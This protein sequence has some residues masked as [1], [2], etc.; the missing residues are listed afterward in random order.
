M[1]EELLGA[2]DPD[3]QLEA[4]QA[5]AGTSDPTDVDVADAAR[6]LIDAAVLPLAT[7]P[8]LRT[9]ILELRHSYDQIIDDA[10]TDSVLA[11]V[12][13]PSKLAGP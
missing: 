5:I 4:A 12:T 3:R 10:S 8:E 11:A 13:R 1:T 7:N 9:A 6:V 2:L